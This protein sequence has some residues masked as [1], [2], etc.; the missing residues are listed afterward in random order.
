[1][2]G[3]VMKNSKYPNYNQIFLKRKVYGKNENKKREFNK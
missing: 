2:I 3:A 1:M